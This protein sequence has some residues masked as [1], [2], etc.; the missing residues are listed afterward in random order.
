MKLKGDIII[1]ICVFA[2]CIISLMAVYSSTKTLSYAAHNASSISYMAKHFFTLIIG[3]AFVYICHKL[4]FYIYAKLKWIAFGLSIVFLIWALLFGNTINDASR[5]IELPFIGLTF[6]ASDFAKLAMVLFVASSLAS[7]QKYITNF[8]EAFLPI[9]IPLVIVCALII[10]ADLSTAALLFTTCLIL[11]FIGRIRLMHI[12][13]ALFASV[14]L[15]SLFISL[16]SLTGYSGRY[17]TWKNRIIHYMDD[18]KES[19][20]TEQAKIAI[21]SGGIL[22]G[23]GPGNSDQSNFLPNPYSDYIYV[24]IIEE[25]GLLGGLFI[26]A[27]YLILLTRS[28]QIFVKIPRAFGALLAV[29]LSLMI[30]LQ[31]FINMAVNVQLLP[32]TGLVLPL[33]SKGGTSL[34]FTG[35]AIGIILSVSRYVEE[36]ELK[37]K[38]QAH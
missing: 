32:V 18:N 36:E 8:K 15:I 21:A 3:L 4:P 14:L 25:Y 27:I 31:A 30:V 7:N 13:F 38:L 29:G 2:L 35:I 12:T 37:L 34:V 20:Q 10:P 6:Q 11:M 28:I 24:I 22:T 17:E 5:W 1:W 19:W 9:F 16:A 33:I 26:I 23:K